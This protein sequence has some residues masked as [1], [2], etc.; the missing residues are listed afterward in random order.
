MSTELRELFDTA[1]ESN[2][3]YDLG[4]RAVAGA[5]HRRQRFVVAGAV[6]ASVAMVLG[7]AVVSGQL[8][9]DASPRPTDVATL[10]DALPAADGLPNLEPG[11]V[12]AASA[13]YVVDG[14][15]VV[16]DAATGGGAVIDTLLDPAGYPLTGSSP[17]LG[18]EGE[19]ALSPNGRYLW[20]STGPISDGDGAGQEWMWLI[21][22]A[23]ADVGLQ[24]SLELAS[25]AKNSTARPSRMTWSPDGSTFACIC[26]FLGRSRP[27]LFM[28]DMTAVSDDLV[29]DKG[30]GTGV[31]PTQISWGTDG[32]VA[33][34]PEL[35]GDWRLVPPGNGSMA[36][37]KEW[38]TISSVLDPGAID[39]FVTAVVM[40]QSRQGGFLGVMKVYR[41]YWIVND[42]REWTVPSV[43]VRPV[44][45][46]LGSSYFTV[47][48]DWK[49]DPVDYEVIRIDSNGETPFTTLP[50]GSTTVAFASDLID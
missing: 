11:V 1:A 7:V 33:R 18:V 8:Q 13:A 36:D 15:V 40:G 34:L 38:P 22:V 2:P 6:L 41:T 44:L 37:P 45:G 26:T 10:P 20:V 31:T 29:I 16:I 30:R 9:P 39:Q 46:A 27:E 19:I 32:L 42:V 24:E 48:T 43:S 17:S 3:P 12:D 21:D 14:E 35:G 5:R 28:V 25:A 4:E 50:P 23:T 47:F 49:G